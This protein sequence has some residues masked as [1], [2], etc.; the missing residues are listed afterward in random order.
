MSEEKPF[1]ILSIPNGTYPQLEQL[2][3]LLRPFAKE[4]NLVVTIK[5]IEPTSFSD[6][7][8][9]L[10]GMLVTL[11]NMPVKVVPKEAV[12]NEVLDKE[13]RAKATEILKKEGRL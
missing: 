7:K 11:N 10:E 3:T 9:W 1:F 4:N 13:I 12:I 8:V 2:K 6:L 5:N